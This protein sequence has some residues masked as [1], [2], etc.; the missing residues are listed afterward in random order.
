MHLT[1]YS[2]NKFPD[3]VDPEATSQLE[4]A[5]IGS[6]TASV[7][8]G[9][10]SDA[11]CLNPTCVETKTNW[12]CKRRLHHFIQSGRFETGSNLTPTTFWPKVDELVRNTVFALVPYLR[13]AYWAECGGFGVADSGSVKSKDP[14]QCFQVCFN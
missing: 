4:A 12:Q 11:E 14:P 13:V 6:A 10:H 3:S 1:N 5:A 9:S 8:G 2:I 7:R